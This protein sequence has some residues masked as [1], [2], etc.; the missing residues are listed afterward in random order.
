MTMTTMV[1]A[2]A[3]MIAT[4]QASGIGGKAAHK[5]LLQR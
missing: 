2:A 4:D 3:T 5:C 1:T